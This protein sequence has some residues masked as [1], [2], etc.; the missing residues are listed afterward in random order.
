MS[1]G[2]LFILW[3]LLLFLSSKIWRFCHTGLRLAFMDLASLQS[4]Q[5]SSGL[6]CHCW[7]VW[8]VQ[9]D[10]ATAADSCELNC[11]YPD[12][13]DWIDSK[14]L[15]LTR[16]SSSSALINLSFPLSLV[17]GGLEGRIMCLSNLIKLGFKNISLLTSTIQNWKK[18]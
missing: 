9:I 4:L 8:G 12:N 7:F 15:F 17:G 18:K 13:A 11:W 5:V 16:S 1:M 3:Y 6:N 2:D 14:E 10:R